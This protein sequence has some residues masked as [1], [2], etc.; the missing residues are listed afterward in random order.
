[1]TP[2]HTEMYNEILARAAVVVDDEE[3]KEM[4]IGIKMKV[5]CKPD[6]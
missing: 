1:M 6:T 5:K 2:Y 3:E 4:G